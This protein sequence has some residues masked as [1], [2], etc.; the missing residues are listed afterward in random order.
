[1]NVHR[2]GLDERPWL[3]FAGLGI[4]LAA[5]TV[6]GGL[7]GAWVDSRA[8]WAK[9]YATACGGLVGFVAAMIR[10]VR[11]ALAAPIHRPDQTPGS[12]HERSSA[13]PTFPLPSHP[14]EHDDT[15]E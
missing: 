9:P 5:T 1:M 12:S 13:E 7:L 2:R 6:A 15:P 10:F 8:G 3:R 4:G 11:V 14:T